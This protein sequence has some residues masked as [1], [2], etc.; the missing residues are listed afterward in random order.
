MHLFIDS[1]TTGLPKNW[2]A[3]V[4]DLNNWPRV[5]QLGWGRYDAKGRRLGMESFI[6][7]PEGFTIPHDAQRVHGISTSRAL[8]EGHP[9]RAVLKALAAAA[10]EAA[11]LVAHNLRFDENVIGAEF[12][13]AGIE[14]PFHG[15]SRVCT[16]LETTAFCGLPGPCGYKWPTLGELHEALFGEQPAQSHDAEADIESCAKCF[17][18]LKRRRILGMTPEKGFSRR[19]VPRA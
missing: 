15:K 18:E 6:V 19:G 4:T 11:V 16:M 14:I 3:P 2:K 1:E 10:S 7:K 9:L 5:V 13:R 8:A 17:Y 12:L